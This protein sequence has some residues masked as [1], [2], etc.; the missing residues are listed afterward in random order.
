M[1]P[2]RLLLFV[3]IFDCAIVACAADLGKIDR[4]IKKEPTYKGKPSYC[5]LLFGPAAEK[6]IWVVRDGDI[7]YVDRNGNGD[8]TDEGERIQGKRGAVTRSEAPRQR[9]QFLVEG[10]TGAKGEKL[11]F[12]YEYYEDRTIGDFLFL[13]EDFRIEPI[14]LTGKQVQGVTGE[15]DFS[16]KR[17]KCPVY[18]FQGPLTFRRVGQTKFVR[19]QET[20]DL[21]VRIGT[22][23]FGKE[24][25]AKIETDCVPK[26][27]HPK[28]EIVFPGKSASDAP[29]KRTI[30]LK[31]R[32]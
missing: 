14:Q 18:H 22:A 3:F 25:F 26:D 4:S 5:L 16:Q 2:L 23:G 31:N 10:I 8:L 32:C 17:E 12:V 15:F 20:E 6:R 30:T 21:I 9:I 27:V 11:G 13:Y 28:A 24:S 29:I 1:R 7:L 19:G